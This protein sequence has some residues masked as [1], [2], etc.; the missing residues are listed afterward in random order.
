METMPTLQKGRETE[1][2]VYLRDWVREDKSTVIIFSLCGTCHLN[3]SQNTER[4]DVGRLT[5][6]RDL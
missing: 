5:T 4:I 3:V 6:N 1:P 2:H